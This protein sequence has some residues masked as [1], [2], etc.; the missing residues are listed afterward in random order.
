ML[1]HLQPAKSAD[2]N[3]GPRQKDP[4]HRQDARLPH[5]RY[6]ERP[7]FEGKHRGDAAAPS[8]GVAAIGGRYVVTVF[9]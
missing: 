2:N 7:A 1:D 3:N 6:K 5:R 4:E 9:R 8:G